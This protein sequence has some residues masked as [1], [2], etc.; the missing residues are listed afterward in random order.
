MK[1]VLNG[2][3]SITG[4]KDKYLSLCIVTVLLTSVCNA[5]VFHYDSTKVKQKVAGTFEYTNGIAVRNLFT[6]P[7]GRPQLALKDSGSITYYHGNQYLWNG[8][9]WVLSAG[10]SG[11]VDSN[12]V[13]FGATSLLPDSSGFILGSTVASKIFKFTSGGTS[14]SGGSGLDSTKI[15]SLR[16]IGLIVQA[17]K[18]GTW[19]NQYNDSVGPFSQWTT[20]SLGIHYNK[21]IAIH[22]AADT[23][24][25]TIV[26]DEGKNGI[27]FFGKGTDANGNWYTSPNTHYIPMLQYMGWKDNM[28]YHVAA[29]IAAIDQPGTTLLFANA[30]RSASLQFNVASAYNGT[31]YGQYLQQ[32]MLIKPNIY[33]PSVGVGLGV[34]DSMAVIDV[35]SNNKGAL[36]APRMTT[37]TINS[38]S[39]PPHMVVV[40]NL[41]SNF[42]QYNS[43]TTTSPVWS[44]LGGATVAGTGGGTVT[45]FA[46][47]NGI[48]ILTSLTNPT[49]TPNLTISVDTSVITHKSFL[50]AAL[51]LKQNT[52]TT[53]STSQYLRGDLSLATL[54]VTDSTIFQTK[55]RSDTARARSLTSISAKQNILKLTTIGLSGVATLSNDTLNIPSPAYGTY[56]PTATTTTNASACYANSATYFRIGNMVHVFLTGSIVVSASGLA[57]GSVT[58]PYSTT[59]SVGTQLGVATI[60]PSAGGYLPAGVTLGTSTTARFS[61]TATASGNATYNLEIDYTAP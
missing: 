21:N 13:Q 45:S 49:T 38:L 3:F 26:N 40:A 20:D 14:T 15:D 2:L 6:I 53:G 33:G 50:T 8:T 59:S 1:K 23:S 7:Y 43:G 5:Q 24:A 54:P 55:Y 36:I 60:M 51:A 37:T 56:F 31:A 47:T 22:R 27:V 32:G 41:D 35:N 39:V 57:E 28:P 34:P 30:V 11:G 44:R 10:G 29:E 9:G 16:K 46:R 58:L 19:R 4:L 48:G 17:R 25:F 61:F 42:F 18:N 52:I 12:A